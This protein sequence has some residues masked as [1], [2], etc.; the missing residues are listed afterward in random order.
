MANRL[1]KQ[2]GGQQNNMSQMIEN[3]KQF[4]QGLKDPE[5]QM[6]ALLSSGRVNQQMLNQAQQMARS[7]YDMMKSL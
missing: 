3:I 5:K 7:I 4:K 2:F 1:S 6:Q